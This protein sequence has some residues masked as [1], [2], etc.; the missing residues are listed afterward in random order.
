MKQFLKKNFINL[1]ILILIGNLIAFFMEPGFVRY[2]RMWL[3][4]CLFSLA[5]G[6]PMLKINEYI[7]FLVGKKIKWEKA[8]LK[9]FCLSLLI[10][11]IFATLVTVLINYTYCFLINNYSFSDCVASTANMLAIEIL[12]IIYVFTIFTGIE[13]FAKWREAVEKQESLQR[14]A[15]EL[16][17]EALKNQVN[18]HFLFNSLNT[19]TSLVYKDADKAARFIMQLSD[20]YRYVLEH[21]QEPTVSWEDERLFVNNYV[22]LQQMR[23]LNNIS[24]HV[25]TGIPG[26]VQVIPLSVQMLVENAIKHNEITADNPLRISIYHE[27][28]YLVVQNNLQLKTS[29]EY[30]GNVGLNNI[31]LQY[32]LLTGKKVDVQEDE[33]YFIVKLPMIITKRGQNERTDR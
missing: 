33:T 26:N 25:D 22:Q 15:I 21:K 4:N 13:F 6:F 31:R 19:L 17:M 5:V 28:E 32:E 3:S 8:P 12:I 10:I 20:I 14:K 11:I 16:Q 2:P 29:T 18:P 23:F 1:I 24:V 9:R 27:N 7:I 30:S